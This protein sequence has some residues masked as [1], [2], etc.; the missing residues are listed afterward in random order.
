MTGATGH[1][2][3]VAMSIYCLGIW[4][5]INILSHMVARAG[6]P[7]IRICHH[8]SAGEGADKELDQSNP[9]GAGSV[10]CS[11]QG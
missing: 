10:P 9:M 11:T 7:H 6:G 4:T 1:G 3:S 2:L 8:D 5:E